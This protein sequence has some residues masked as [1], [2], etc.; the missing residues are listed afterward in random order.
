LAATARLQEQ[1]GNPV[2]K[3]FDPLL[4][5]IG[6]AAGVILG[7]VIDNIAIGI[8]LGLGAGLALPYVKER[9]GRSGAK[10]AALT[11]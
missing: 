1:I 2:L 3:K 6:L 10:Q 5:S 9:S 4:F 7:V 8:L 11:F